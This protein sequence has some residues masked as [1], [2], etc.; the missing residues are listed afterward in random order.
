MG[1]RG[2]MAR[3]PD[4]YDM[5]GVNRKATLDEIRRAYRRLALNI[6]P[7]RSS[8]PDAAERFTR[9]TQAYEVLRDPQARRQYDEDLSR[10]EY[11]PQP[12]VKPQP[13]PRAKPNKVAAARRATTP[14]TARLAAL[15]SRGKLDEAE[16]LAERI[17]DN[18]PREALPYAILG[19]IARAR[20]QMAKASKLYA[21]AVQMDPRNHAY[22]HR[23]EQLLLSM[24]VTQVEAPSNPLGASVSAFVIALIACLYLVVAKE[25]PAFKDLPFISTWTVGCFV[26]L[27]LTGVATGVSLSL[28]RMLDRF[29]AVSVTALGKLSPT[30]ALASVAI[31]NFWA[32]VVLYVAL[33]VSQQSFNYS[34]TRLIGASVA[35]LLVLTM[36]ASLS[37]SIHPAQVFLWGGN[38]LYL[39]SV[40]G[41]MVGDALRR[42]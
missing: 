32:A 1:S 18:F 27:F 8:A 34:A 35:G 15:F 22:Q 21:Y 25:K 10:E 9:L 23:Y 26:M 3:G 7:D 41:W 31:V 13:Q 29:S 37:P 5:L 14:E 6:H 4:H 33:G 17:I 12:Q 11:R 20:G 28:G 42:G 38:V 36:G 16:A 19:D 24:G 30:V 40:S 2:K 39:G